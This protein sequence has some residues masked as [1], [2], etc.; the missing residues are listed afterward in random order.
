MFIHMPEHDRRTAAAVKSKLNDLRGDAI[1]AGELHCMPLPLDDT[2]FSSRI[3]GI[4]VANSTQLVV[5]LR[6]SGYL[7]QE[8]LL[9]ADPRRP[10]GSW[11]E[12][13][14]QS[15]VPQL[16]RD[17]LAADKSALN[18]EMNRAW[19]SHEMC[20]TFAHEMLEFCDSPLA[21]CQR[22]GWSC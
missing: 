22:Y 8:G 9:R 17:S 2:F 20:A 14:Q 12:A 19:A 3:N 6:S 4:S 21:T 7:T 18:E 10:P 1:L 15:G 13:L 5:A 11:R 16:L